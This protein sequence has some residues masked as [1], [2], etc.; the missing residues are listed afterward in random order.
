MINHLTFR[1]PIRTRASVSSL[2]GI[3]VSRGRAGAYRVLQGIRWVS[4]DRRGEVVS[5]GIVLK[6][7]VT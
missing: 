6:E 4:R 7:G 3:G 1:H 2:A 5:M